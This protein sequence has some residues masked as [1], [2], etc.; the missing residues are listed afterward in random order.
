MSVALNQVIEL[1]KSE[2]ENWK[3]D[4][5]T[6]EHD[7]GISIWTGNVPYFNCGIYIPMRKVGF[8]DRIRLQV[9]VNRWHKSCGV[10]NK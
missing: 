6:L 5:Y 9:A 10:L 8:F 1:L 3:Q 4:D 2:P 7:D